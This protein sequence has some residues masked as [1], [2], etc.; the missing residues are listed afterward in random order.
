MLAAAAAAVVAFWSSYAKGKMNGKSI[1]TFL[2]VEEDQDNDTIPSRYSIQLF[3]MPQ[4]AKGV[5]D[6]I[7][8]MLEKMWH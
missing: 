1:S 4:A 8:K 2:N 5:R 3:A 6:K 7:T